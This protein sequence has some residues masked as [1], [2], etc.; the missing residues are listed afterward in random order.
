MQR[1]SNRIQGAKSK[2]ERHTHLTFRTGLCSEDEGGYKEQDSA[3][4]EWSASEALLLC[5]HVKADTQCI[6]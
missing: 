5:P 4:R 1:G 2:G 3:L 6:S